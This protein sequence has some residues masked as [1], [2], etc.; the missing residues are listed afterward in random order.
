MKKISSN[1]KLLFAANSGMMGI[2][3]INLNSKYKKKLIGN[4][5][6]SLKWFVSN[7]KALFEP[8][9]SKTLHVKF[10]LSWI[11]LTLHTEI[12]QAVSKDFEIPGLWDELELDRLPLEKK[13]EQEQKRSNVSRFFI[14]L[15]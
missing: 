1:K 12:P 6:R 4:S 8:P 7:K 9:C 11:M 5:K 14:E 3:L 2:I 10:S 15:I 13:T